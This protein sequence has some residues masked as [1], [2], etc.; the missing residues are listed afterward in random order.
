[1]EI[2]NYDRPKKQK[3]IRR[4]DVKSEIRECHLGVGKKHNNKKKCFETK[5]AGVV[6]FFNEKHEICILKKE[7]GLIPIGGGQPLVFWIWSC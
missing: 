3:V 2:S 4:E 5:T 7:S 1:M 6:F